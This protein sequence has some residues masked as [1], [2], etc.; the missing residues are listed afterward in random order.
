MGDDFL[1]VVGDIRHVRKDKR[2]N[3]RRNLRFGIC[4]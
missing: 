4:G 3:E 1:E 2:K